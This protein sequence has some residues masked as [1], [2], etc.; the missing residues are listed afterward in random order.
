MKNFVWFLIL[1]HLFITISWIANSMYL[2][3]FWGIIIWLACIVFGFTAYKR[4]KQHNTLSKIILYSSTFMI[5]LLV[6]T[7][8]IHVTVSSMP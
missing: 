4:I 7:G 3:T 1:F 6:I 2:F 8:L 5:F